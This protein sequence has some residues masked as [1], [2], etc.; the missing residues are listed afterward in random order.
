[1]TVTNGYCG[2]EEL[3]EVLGISDSADDPALERAV[4]AASRQIDAY[5]DRRFWQDGV[6][7]AREFFA[8]DARC[9]EVDDISTT[10]GLVVKL[11]DAGDGTYSTTLTI[12]T[13]FILAPVNAAD[14]VPV[15]PFS[16]IR[17]VGDQ[18]VPR[19]LHGRPQVQVTARFGWPAI[20]DD[21]RQACIVQSKNLFKAPGGAF[22]GYQFSME[23]GV[24]V[25]SPG[26]D[27]VSAALLEP[28]RRGWV[29]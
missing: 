4:S 9:V 12:G 26:I 3:C 24:V 1:M 13:D 16:Q 19:S 25:R 20:P 18:L 17:L 8:H 15:W 11:D 10:T 5:T 2:V 21:V 29:G 7:V 28:Y 23:T 6:V 27:P 22:T 14:M